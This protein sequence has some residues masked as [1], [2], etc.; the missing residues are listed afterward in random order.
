MDVAVELMDRL[1]AA[2]GGYVLTCEPGEDGELRVIVA[3]PG[4][5]RHEVAR[6]TLRD[7]V[8][9][10]RDEGHENVDLTLLD[11]DD[12]TIE[13]RHRLALDALAPRAV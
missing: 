13:L 1:R 5:R 9:T 10:V 11:P 6:A 7:V 8:E 12:A 4:A 2:T 3:V